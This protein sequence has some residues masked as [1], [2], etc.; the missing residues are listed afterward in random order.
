MLLII[1]I[2]NGD[3][4]LNF[5]YFLYIKNSIITAN[6]SNIATVIVY[7]KL[8]IQNKQICAF[9]KF[10]ISIFKHSK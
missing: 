1:D 6:I 7:I 10:D 3:F 9:I 4:L 5:K 8:F 2:T